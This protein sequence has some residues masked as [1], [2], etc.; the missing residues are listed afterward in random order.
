[1]DGAR[2]GILG[3]DM[4]EEEV[5]QINQYGLAI[6]FLNEQMEAGAGLF[7]TALIGSF[8]T[9]LEEMLIVVEDLSLSGEDLTTAMARIELQSRTVVAGLNMIGVAFNVQGESAHRASQQIIAASGGL[10]QFGR[11]VQYYFDN[12]LTEEQRT[13]FTLDSSVQQIKDFNEQFGLTGDNAIH[14]KQQLIDFINAQ[15]LSSEAGQRAFAAALALAPALDAATTAIEKLNEAGGNLSLIKL[16]QP[17]DPVPGQD[18]NNPNVDDPV[19]GALESSAAT[20]VSGIG[21]AISAQTSALTSALSSISAAINS[22]ELSVYVDS[23]DLR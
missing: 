14:T 9:S 11:N 13:Q 18:I 7:D 1:V 8:N 16:V 2:A 23:S 15:D 5:N 6:A 17:D 4:T 21:S 3:D 12:Y 19:L 22:L 20:I 10:E